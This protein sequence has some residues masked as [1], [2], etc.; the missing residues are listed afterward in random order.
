MLW[1]AAAD[2][3]WNQTESR[4]SEGQGS[5]LT[6]QA[7]HACQDYTYQ[8]AKWLYD[9]F[10]R[11]DSIERPRKPA[12]CN[13]KLVDLPGLWPDKAICYAP[14]S[15]IK[16]LMNE[17]RHLRK[18]YH[19]LLLMRTS[20]GFSDETVSGQ[21]WQDHLGIKRG[22]KGAAQIYAFHQEYIECLRPSLGSEKVTQCWQTRISTFLVLCPSPASTSCSMSWDLVL[23]GGKRYNMKLSI[24]ISNTTNEIRR[25]DFH[26][27][28]VKSVQVAFS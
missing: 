16:S 11:L 23:K 15:L 7:R 21:S 8:D 28:P 9:T 10:H 24:W 26:V 6:I 2:K 17:H 14:E 20:F 1:V 19:K 25:L 27:D 18:F 13:S 5:A 4:K 3:S 22:P 12:I